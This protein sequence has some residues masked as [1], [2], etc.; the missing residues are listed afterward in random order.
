MAH[1]TLSHSLILSSSR[2][3]LLSYFLSTSNAH[4]LILLLQV[5]SSRLYQQIPQKYKPFSS[6]AHRRKFPM[7]LLL[8]HHRRNFTFCKV[9]LSSFLSAF[10]LEFWFFS[11]FWFQLVYSPHRRKRVVSGVQPTGSIHLGNYLGAIKNWVA[12]QV[13]F[14]YFVYDIKHTLT[15]R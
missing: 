4:W 7:L 8:R 5:L 2:Y 12:L 10:S 11:L 13:L 15:L 14:S 6:S 9:K 3:S 1:A